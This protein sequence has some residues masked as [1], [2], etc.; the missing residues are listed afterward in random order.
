[1]R[2]PKCG[3]ISF[4]HLATCL[5]CSKDFSEL[6]SAALGTTFSVAPPAFLKFSRNAEPMEDDVD[7]EPVDDDLEPELDVVDPDLDILIK[8]EEEGIAFHLDDDSFKNESEELKDDFAVSLDAEPDTG[9]GDGEIVVDLSQFEDSD[10]MSSTGSAAEEKLTIDLPD[11][12][13]DISDLAPPSLSQAQAPAKPEK[14]G[15]EDEMNFDMVDLD[16]KLDG[17][18]MDF[19][20]MSTDKDGLEEPIDRL[21]LDDIDA[22]GS[23]EK[24]PPPPSPATKAVPSVKSG[25]M[26]MDADLDFELDLG[27]LTIPRK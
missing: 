3:Y 25:E 14:K 12:L 4:D 18:D 7:L 19:S 2:C 9:S 1:M 8:D 10:S 17:L 22:S 6:E 26:D 23:G 20:L 16:L 24:K 11:E 27:G 5:N 13:A 21:S 15:I